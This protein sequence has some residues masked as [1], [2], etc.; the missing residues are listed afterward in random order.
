MAEAVAWAVAVGVAGLADIE[1]GLVAKVVTVAE[2]GWLGGSGR[3]S[4]IESSCR[5]LVG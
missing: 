3:T 1:E 5:T 4:T 2:E